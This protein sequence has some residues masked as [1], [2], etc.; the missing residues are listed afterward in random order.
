LLSTAEHEYTNA[1]EG[2]G[3]TNTNVST[4][5]TAL[6]WHPGA[7]LCRQIL[8]VCEPDMN[9]FNDGCGCGCEVTQTPSPRLDEQPLA[10]P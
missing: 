8:F 10:A 6:S 5:C 4:G 2:H 3:A 1:I 7:T 9:P